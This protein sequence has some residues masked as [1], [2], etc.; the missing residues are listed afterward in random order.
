[1][2]AYIKPAIQ[3]FNVGTLEI[4]ANTNTVETPVN[5]GYGQGGPSAKKWNG[6]DDQEDDGIYGYEKWDIKWSK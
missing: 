3:V 6:F 5:D 1:M 2:K 4:L